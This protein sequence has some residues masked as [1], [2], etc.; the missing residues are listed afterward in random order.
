MFEKFFAKY[1]RAVQD[2]ARRCALYRLYA[3]KAVLFI[4]S[5]ALSLAVIVEA[6]VVAALPEDKLPFALAI[7]FLVTLA[8]W[9]IC[10]AALIAVTL[11]FRSRYNA[12]LN[13]PASEGELPEVTAYRQKTAQGRRAA[14]KR[15]WWTWAVFGVCIAAFIVCLVMETIYN[16]GDDLGAWG[17]ASS[18]L[19]AVGILTV[20][21]GYGI[22]KNVNLQ[23]GQTTEQQTAAEAEAIDSAQG[24][25]HSYD[26][27]SDPNIGTYKYLFPNRRLYAAAEEIRRKY[28]KLTLVV[29]IVLAIAAIAVITVLYSPEI[30]GADVKGYA[31]PAA[32]T[33]LFGGLLV[34]TLPANIKLTALEREQKRELE[35]NPEYAKYYEWY[36]LYSGF[37]RFKGKIYLIFIAVSVILAWVLA[38]VLPATLCSALSLIPLIGGLLLNQALVKGLRRQ[39]IPIEREIDEALRSAQDEDGAK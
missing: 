12:I 25:K 21:L 1:A 2:E 27:Q 16:T 30:T 15:L 35:E 20:I 26:L 10:G 32:F 7:A 34:C 8:L 36:K 13:L 24:R 31:V 9:L 14:F 4:I 28:S 37:A 22:Y 19:L 6:C 11:V 5:M 33:L 38:A 23:K 18:V 39:A 29:G 17:I 3:V